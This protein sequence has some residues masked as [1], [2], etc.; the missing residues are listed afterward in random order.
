MAIW[1]VQQTQAG[2]I[3][4]TYYGPDATHD[5]GECSGDTPIR[6]IQEWILNHCQ[7]YDTIEIEH[8]HPISVLPQG[9]GNA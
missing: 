9:Q 7:P 6:T 8:G 3:R 2:T 5:C 4:L 1:R